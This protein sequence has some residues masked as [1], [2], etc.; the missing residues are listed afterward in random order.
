MRST[1]RALGALVLVASTLVIGGCAS[2]AAS[3]G[4]VEPGVFLADV[5]APDVIV[6]DVRTPAEFAAGHL[7]G[8]RN[9]DVEGADFASQVAA[10][11]PSAT[12]AVY[13]RSGRRSAL[14]AA[15][16]SELGFRNVLDLNGGLAD[17]QAAG[18]Q[19]V[20]S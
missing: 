7:A 17:L 10:L 20:T 12:Y 3:G 13:C 9:I 16:L 1:L 14:A 19:V 2:T 15:K 11:D 18:A 4:K 8:A 6:L 5:A